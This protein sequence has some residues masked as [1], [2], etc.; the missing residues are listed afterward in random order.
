VIFDQDVILC[1]NLQVHINQGVL[2]TQRAH[3]F[4]SA[5]H[6]QSGRSNAPPRLHSHMDPSVPF[7]HATQ[8]S[9]GSTSNAVYISPA[10]P[11]RR[12]CARAAH[13]SQSSS[14]ATPQ[15]SND[16][17]QVHLQVRV[18]PAVLTSDTK[19]HFLVAWCVGGMMAWLAES[20][21][22]RTFAGQELAR[23]A[24]A[25]ELEEKSGHLRAQQELAAAREEV[26]RC[27]LAAEQQ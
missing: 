5:A 23:R 25:K 16:C 2:F 10:G 7:F 3:P 14:C 8:L 26:R 12:R 27:V 24:H 15:S 6:D 13:E 20:Y 21:R 4:D 22:R 19:Q 1:S 9:D 11:H 18:D 17:K